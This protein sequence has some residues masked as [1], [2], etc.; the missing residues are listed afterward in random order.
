MTNTT[1]EKHGPLLYRVG[2][3]GLWVLL[4]KAFLWVIAPFVFFYFM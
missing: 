3:V 4:I 2:I 1:L